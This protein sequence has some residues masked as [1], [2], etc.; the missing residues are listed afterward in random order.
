MKMAPPTRATLQDLWS[1][2]RLHGGLDAMLAAERARF[3][4]PILPKMIEVGA[5]ELE[6]VLPWDEQYEQT[7]GEACWKFASY[8]DYLTA[9][10]SRMRFPRLR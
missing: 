5:S 4:P 8:P 7:P 2:H 3:V 9:L 6:I 1:S 10:P